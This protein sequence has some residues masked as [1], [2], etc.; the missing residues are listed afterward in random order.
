MKSNGSFGA[1]HVFENYSIPCSG[2]VATVDLFVGFRACDTSN[3]VTWNDTL[4]VNLIFFEADGVDTKN[5]TRKAMI[6]LSVLISEITTNDQALDS[7]HIIT[8]DLAAS[9]VTIASPHSR[10]ALELPV[11][12]TNGSQTTHYYIPLLNLNSVGCNSSINI[13]NSSNASIF[14]YGRDS[15]PPFIVTFAANHTEEETST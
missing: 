15:L 14:C 5:Y 4:S 13:T 3:N 2:R 8:L 7:F 11:S 9:N 6:P 1:I 10:V 12:D